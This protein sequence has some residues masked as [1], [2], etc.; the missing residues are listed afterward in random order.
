MIR[1]VLRGGSS[2]YVTWYLR[3]TYRYWYQPEN[4]FRYVGFR[5]IIR[6]QA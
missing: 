4:R 3:S 1:R 2:F 5:L 6:R